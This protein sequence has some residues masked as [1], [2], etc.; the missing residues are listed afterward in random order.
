MH[1]SLS[2]HNYRHAITK[3][4]SLEEHIPFTTGTEAVQTLEGISSPYACFADKPKICQIAT[5]KDKTGNIYWFENV[6]LSEMSNRLKVPGNV[7]C[8]KALLDHTWI[9]CTET[10]RSTAPKYLFFKE[11][12]CFNLKSPPPLPPIM[13]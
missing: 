3:L 2:K 1:A 13:C 10:K 8:S 6:E 4:E 11:E 12:L 5:L 7:G 9:T